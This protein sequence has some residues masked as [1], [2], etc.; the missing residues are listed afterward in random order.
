[1]KK[2]HIINLEKMGG[3]ERLFLQYV[4]EDIENTNEILCIN[5]V[6]G[7]EIE[8]KLSGKKINYV[9]R[10]FNAFSTRY[11]QFL[12]KFVLKRKIEKANADV[13]IV[14]DLV[15]VLSAK[16]AR[17]KLVYYD[18]GCSWRYPKNSKTLG[19]F[20][21]LDGVISASWASKR[22]MEL[23][24][25]LPLSVEVLPNRILTPTG[26][27]HSP[28]VPPDTLRIGTASRLVT[29]KGISV[30]LLMMQELIR[31]GHKVQLEIAGK[32]PDR[33]LFETLTAKLQLSEHVIFTGFQD[34]VADFFN[35]TDVYMST[36]ITEPFGL[37]CLEA[38]YFGVPVIFPLVDG[39]PE[40]IKDKECGLGL[41]PTVSIEEHEK[42][43]GIH[44]D[45]PY[46]VYDPVKDQ[47]VA[48]KLLCHIDC[49]NAIEQLLQKDN[50]QRMSENAYRLTTEALDYASFKTR[51]EVILTRFVA[52]A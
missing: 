38:L 18:H 45:F 25:N 6:V 13:I 42:L 1:M 15:P 22:V 44:I 3:V 41:T 27:H 31:R 37:S 5:S 51:F 39:Q 52:I 11:P 26:I 47:L 23:R 7:S 20:S 8:K 2:L 34:N 4:N 9:N 48:P 35:R 19:F 46:D 17:G 30:S 36:P 12:R 43:T 49:A 24:F 21:M 28:K 50:Y 33:A 32:G 10:I 16:P 29:L 40:A 14:W